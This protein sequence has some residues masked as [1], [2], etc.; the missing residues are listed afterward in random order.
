MLQGVPKKI[1]TKIERC[2]AKF[3][4]GHDY[5]GLYI[6]YTYILYIF[7]LDDRVIKKEKRIGGQAIYILLPM[8]SFPGIGAGCNTS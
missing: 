3:S 7:I 5:G 8:I 4:H 6:I 1:L 2:G